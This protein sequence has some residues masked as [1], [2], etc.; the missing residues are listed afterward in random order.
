MNQELISEIE[1]EIGKITEIQ[2]MPEQGCTSRVHRLDTTENS[3]IVKSSFKDKYR[4]WLNSEAKVLKD[5]RY[6]KALVPIYHAFIEEEEA[7]HL[8]MSY[9]DGISLTT[10]LKQAGSLSEKKKLIRSFGE[11][12]NQFHESEAVTSETGSDWLDNQLTIARSYVESG[13]AE[14]DLKLLEEIISTKP[15][16][17]QQT[18]IHGDCTTDNVLVVNGKVELFIDV[19]G[20]TIGDP[21]YDEA[22]AI[23]KFIGKHGFLEAFYQGYTRSRISKSEYEYFEEGLYMFF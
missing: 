14:G 1:A 21:R 13:Q 10:A 7:S 9:V 12:L 2:L 17:V 5:H 22:L 3:Y 19:A 16:P 8:I 20:M 11:F 6:K 15:H 18:M 23:R 4:S